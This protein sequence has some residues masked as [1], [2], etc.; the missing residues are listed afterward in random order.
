MS[1]SSSSSQARPMRAT[2]HRTTLLRLVAAAAVLMLVLGVTLLQ[3]T[4]SR[5]DSSSSNSN[6]RTALSPAHL[7]QTQRLLLRS[8][9]RQEED[10]A[11]KK[12]DKHKHKEEA[13]PATE[14][15]AVEEGDS[16]DGGD[17]ETLVDPTEAVVATE[18]ATEPAT[19]PAATEAADTAV[20][21]KEVVPAVTEPPPRAE[22]HVKKHAKDGSDLLVPKNQGQGPEETVFVEGKT[23]IMDLQA[24]I[25]PENHHR[26]R[27][28]VTIV[29]HPEW[30]PLGAQ[31]F[32]ELVEA[33]FYDDCRFFRVV[34][35]FMVQFGIN[36]RVSRS[37]VGCCSVSARMRSFLCSHLALFCNMFLLHCHSQLHRAIP[38][39]RNNGKRLSWK[40]IPS[41]IPTT[42][43]PCPLPRPDPTHARPNYS[44]TPKPTAT[45][46][47]TSRAFRPLPKLSTAWSTWITFTPSTAKSPVKEKLPSK[48]MR[49]CRKS[50][51]CSLTLSIFTKRRRKTRKKRP[52]R[53][54]GEEGA[55][56]GW[57]A[58]TAARRNR[59]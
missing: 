3:L 37:C 18:A 44:S 52:K 50:T 45:H 22:E 58:W 27:G 15:A 6:S 4:S 25:P 23:F 12:K 57:A 8:A 36:V 54:G 17:E 42:A 49:T 46:S 34:N 14:A 31:H 55:V 21:S 5:V 13:V 26:T 29:T 33:G 47:W 35:D 20:E 32:H 59:E 2:R 16:G 24:L 38:L 48:A 56:H 51:P 10:R 53:R 11:L 19:E 39:S 40:T 30:A 43:R 28:H 1:S 7:L 9:L 41:C